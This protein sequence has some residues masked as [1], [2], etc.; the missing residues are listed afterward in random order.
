M[1]LAPEQLHNIDDI[2]SLIASNTGLLVIIASNN[3][4]N[5][6]S[7]FERKYGMISKMHSARN[8]VNVKIV[9]VDLNEVP[10]FATEYNIVVP[11]GSPFPYVLL[12]KNGAVVDRVEAG[13]M[14][15]IE[16]MIR[17]NL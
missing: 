7:P 16:M 4:N 9:K 15:R 2:H 5:R 8:N 14:P 10:S 3:T 12:I 17:K 6:T 13:H 1:S 11:A